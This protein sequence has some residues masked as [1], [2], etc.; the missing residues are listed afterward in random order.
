MPENELVPGK[1]TVVQACGAIWCF[2]LPRMH[3]IQIDDDG[4]RVSLSTPES[5]STYELVAVD[6][7][8]DEV[9]VKL[10][11]ELSG[12]AVGVGDQSRQ[13]RYRLPLIQDEFARLRGRWA[14]AGLPEQTF[15]AWA[16]GASWENHLH[17]IRQKLRETEER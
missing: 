17:D 13:A 8:E 1:E 9:I 15:N 12:H 5:G 11:A 3:R 7:T 16:Q 10:G 6:E 14:N 2:H 4:R